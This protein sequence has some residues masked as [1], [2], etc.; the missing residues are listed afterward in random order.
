MEKSKRHSLI[1]ADGKEVEQEDYT[2]DPSYGVEQQNNNLPEEQLE[3]NLD[4]YDNLEDEE[5]EDEDNNL[6]D[7][8]LEDED[9]NLEDEELED[10][11]NNLEDEEFEDEDYNLDDEEFED[12]D[13]QESDGEQSFYLEDELDFEDGWTQKTSS[14]KESF[15]SIV[16]TVL[17]GLVCALLIFVKFFWIYSVQVVGDSMN[18]TLQSGDYL[19]VD[20][21]ADINRGDVIV[22][23][24]PDGSGEGADG[25]AYIKRVIA[26]AGDTVVM[27]DG[28]V[29]LKKAGEDHFEL[30]EYEG[31]KGLTYYR[32]MDHSYVPDPFTVSEN[33]V[34][35]LGDNREN[36]RDSRFLDEIDLDNVDGVVTS[37]MIERKDGKL[38]D[39]CGWFYQMRKSIHDFLFGEE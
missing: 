20:K 16:I 31:V 33:H 1:N 23:T 11:D 38:G 9:Y 2:V 15:V 12:Y 7:K 30:V 25:R 22:F 35:V 27:E 37:F 5:L 14:K 39:F 6:E 3:E 24:L 10:E 13:V 29:Y 18:D 19:Y 34:Y 26:T 8:E 4:A 36:S 21:L 28:N 32:P 17:L